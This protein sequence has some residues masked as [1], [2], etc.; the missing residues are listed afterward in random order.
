[1]S[2]LSR[3]DLTQMGVD[4]NFY[5]VGQ[6]TKKDES[7]V[8]KHRRSTEDSSTQK[9]HKGGK[10]WSYKFANRIDLVKP[11]E[12]LECVVVCSGM[13]SGCKKLK[14]APKITKG[15]K[16]CSFMFKNCE[17]L[18]QAPEIPEGVKDCAGMFAYCINLK[19]QPKIPKSAKNYYNIFKG[20]NFENYK[21][22]TF[23][24][25]NLF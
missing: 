16:N 18:E 15:I 11:P 10:D 3:K 17:S 22:K 25:M 19:N 9:S 21:E 23:L 24:T 2:N 5:R 14:Q 6:M 12:I 4:Y 7:T 1:M 8:K 20:C 13:F